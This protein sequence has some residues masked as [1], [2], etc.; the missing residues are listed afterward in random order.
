MCLEP[1]LALRSVFAQVAGEGTTEGIPRGGAGADRG[2]RARPGGVS[3]ATWKRTDPK[4]CLVI[5]TVPFFD[6]IWQHFSCEFESREPVLGI[7][8]L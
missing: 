8:F 7:V 4:L 2:G 1:W 3:S 6:Q 5:T